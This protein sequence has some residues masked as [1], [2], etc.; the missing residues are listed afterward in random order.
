MSLC[1]HCLHFTFHMRIT[2]EC[3]REK[4]TTLIISKLVIGKIV[5]CQCRCGDNVGAASV[6]IGMPY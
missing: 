5:F 6:V 2:G 3:N 1:L 4:H